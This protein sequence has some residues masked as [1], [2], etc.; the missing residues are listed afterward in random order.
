MGVGVRLGIRVGMRIGMVMAVGGC[1]LGRCGRGGQR[2]GRW[3]SL[4][5][6]AARKYAAQNGSDNENGYELGIGFWF[7]LSAPS[8]WILQFIVIHFHSLP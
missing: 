2:R 7:H 1:Y 6:R 8:W 3:N 5:G 4:G